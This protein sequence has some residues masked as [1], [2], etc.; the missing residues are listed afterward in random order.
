METVLI[1]C[2]HCGETMQAPVNRA[3]ILCMFCGEKIEL[4]QAEK[5]EE[6]AGIMEKPADTERTAKCWENPTDAVECREDP[7]DTVRRSS[8]QP[9]TQLDTAKGR[10]NLQFVLSHVGAVCEGYAEKVRAFKR[11][12]YHSLFEGHKAENYAFYT[13]VKLVLENTPEEEL[14]GICRQIAGAFIDEQRQNLEQV[15]RKNEKFSAQMDKNMFMVIYVLPSVKEIQDG[16]A[17]RLAEVICEE[18]RGAF[19]DSKIMASDYDSIM[20]GF[21]RKLCY[22]TTAVCQNLNKGENCEE[23]RLIKE[24]R[25]GYL[26]STKEGQALIDEYYDIAPT[27]VKRIAR[28]DRAQEKYVWL[29]NRYLAP[30]VAYIKGGEPEKCK[31]TYCDMMEELQAEYMTR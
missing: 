14:D 19:K 2:P 22:V 6:S 24:F 26:A 3:S 7:A 4:A 5:P 1:K 25:D 30:C 27:L 20:Q 15:K 10:E 12:S 11:N 18:W 23:L 29:W 28:D 17:D 16:R 31:D 8:R 21:K 9:G 13:S